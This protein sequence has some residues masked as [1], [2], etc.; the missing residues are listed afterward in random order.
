MA[1]P[2]G[3]QGDEENAT[4]AIE[5]RKY[6]SFMIPSQFRECVAI[7]FP[8]RSRPE[9]TWPSCGCAGRSRTIP[10]T[11]NPVGCVLRRRARR[12]RSLPGVR[13]RPLDDHD[14]SRVG[15]LVV[16]AV[17]FSADAVTPD[18]REE[19]GARARGMNP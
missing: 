1:Q 9:P 18:F 3:P 4:P 5:M 14:F 8:P 2:P 16:L 17:I 11:I 19:V 12:N 6:R 10:V 13:R 7:R 15:A